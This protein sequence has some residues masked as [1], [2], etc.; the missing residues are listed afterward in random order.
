MDTLS[1]FGGNVQILVS[2]HIFGVSLAALFA[3]LFV[4]S[5]FLGGTSLVKSN[6]VLQAIFAFIS[7]LKDGF[8]AATAS[9][10]TPP[11]A[12]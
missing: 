3:G 5:E 1:V 2:D 8:K 10:N 6:S 11:A 12:K 7:R 4:V 9:Q